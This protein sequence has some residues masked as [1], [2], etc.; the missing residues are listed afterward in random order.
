[1]R[2]RR[3]G[4]R[5]ATV[6]RAAAVLVVVAVVV[7]AVYSMVAVR[8]I[9]PVAVDLPGSDD[10][11]TYLL[12]GSDSRERVSQARRKEYADRKQ[13]Q[14]ERADLLLV[15]RA[16]GSGPATVV[17]VPR[18]LY[19]GRE[20]GRPHRIGLSLQDGVQQLVSSLCRDVGV[21]VD[22]VLL[23]DFDGLIDLVDAVGGVSVTTRAP[24]RDARARLSLAGPGRQPLD[25]RAALAWVRS[26]HPELKV[27]TRWV[28]DPMADPTRTSHAA[29]VI[30]QVAGKASRN[31][32]ALHRSIWAVGSHLRRDEGL[33]AFGLAHLAWNLRAA[34]AEGRVGTLP[35]R[36]SGTEVPFAFPTADTD[37]ALAPYRSKGCS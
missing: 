27:G 19:V 25:G 24:T 11:R 36:Y 34:T 37:T 23:V 1:M 29:D 33:G 35:A 14:G 28:A 31:P 18:D 15:L 16:P 6:V 7:G 8:R 10:G 21:G 5:L 9:A 32:L 13:A 20:A 2:R 30:E 3:V 4:L 22:H 17:S 26:R 12:V